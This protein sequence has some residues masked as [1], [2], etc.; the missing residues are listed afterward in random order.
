M[1]GNNSVPCLRHPVSFYLGIYSLFGVLQ[2][3]HTLLGAIFLAIGSIRASRIF[4]RRMLKTVLRAPMSFFDTTPLGRI[5][6]RFSKDMYMIDEMIP[7]SVFWCLFC[8]F[9]ILGI[10]AVISYTTPVFLSVVLP[11]G[12]FYFFTQ[13]MHYLLI[14]WGLLCTRTVR[15]FLSYVTLYRDS[16]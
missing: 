8:F 15:H 6:N 14:Y 3:V 5:V 1:L 13:V 7:E 2:S 16:M 11:I 9:L 10:I 4:H 12:V